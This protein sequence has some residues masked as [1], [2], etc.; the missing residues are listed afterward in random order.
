MFKQLVLATPRKKRTSVTKKIDVDDYHSH[1]HGNLKSYKI[2]VD[3]FTKFNIR[4]IIYRRYL[5]GK[6]HAVELEM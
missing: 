2:D 1:R 6:I 3:D 4:R 5:K